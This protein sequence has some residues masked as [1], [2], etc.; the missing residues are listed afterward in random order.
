MIV[1]Y[2]RKEIRSARHFPIFVVKR[3]PVNVPS[4]LPQH[5]QHL[6]LENGVN[7]LD[8]NSRSAL[9]HSKNINHT[10]GV[11]VDKFAQHQAHDFHRNT[12]AT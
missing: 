6:C 1:S 11:V 10:N 3:K 9:G 5:V 8:G 2:R 12:S 4:S 7:S